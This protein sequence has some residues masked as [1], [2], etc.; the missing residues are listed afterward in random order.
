MRARARCEPRYAVYLLGPLL[1]IG[2]FV[3]ASTMLRGIRT[4]AE[5]AVGG[6]RPP[7]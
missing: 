6:S 1:G 3:N 5:L 2:D 4:R 7:G